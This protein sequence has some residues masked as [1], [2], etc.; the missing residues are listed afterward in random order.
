M[1][2]CD[3]WGNCTQGRD[4][5]VRTGKVLPHQAAHAIR[6]GVIVDKIS[7]IGPEGGNYYQFAE[8]GEANHE[9]GPLEALGA[10]LIISVFA[11]LSFA[12]MAGLAGYVIT[13]WLA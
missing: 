11:V 8:P 1:N 2:C 13:R 5:P 6:A 4:C 10:Y 9:L 7:D 12:V 3:T